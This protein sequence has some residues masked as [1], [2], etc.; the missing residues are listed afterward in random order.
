M[1]GILL[2]GCPQP[3][4]VVVITVGSTTITVGQTITVAASSTSATDTSFAY[5][6]SSTAVAT[7]NAAGEV[8]GVAVGTA[9]ISATG[10]S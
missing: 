8:T 3:G 2:A 4:E 7:V 5:S 1:L 9:T 6:S 10:N